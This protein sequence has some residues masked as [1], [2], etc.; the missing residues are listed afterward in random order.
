MLSCSNDYS[1]LVLCDNPFDIVGM[2]YG[3]ENLQSSVITHLKRY[4]KYYATVSTVY[5]NTKKLDFINWL[6]G[7]ITKK[8][9]ADELCL[10]A[11]A[12][13]M[14]IHITVDYLGGIWMML[15]IPHI[16]HDLAIALLDIHLVYRGYCKYNLLCKNTSLKTIG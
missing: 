5:L 6:S 2:I 16:N 1:M 4:R 15:N 8:L 12:T 9:L 11:L 13:F 3:M 10:H 7:M 14:N